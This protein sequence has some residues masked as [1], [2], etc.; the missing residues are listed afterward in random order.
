M[1][2]RRR[3]GVPRR[4]AGAGTDHRRG[5]VPRPTAGSLPRHRR[6]R[7][8]PPGGGPPCPGAGLDPPRGA[9][10]RGRSAVPGTAPGVVTAGGRAHWPPPPPRPVSTSSIFS[11]IACGSTRYVPPAIA[12]CSASTLAWS[13]PGAVAAA[14][15]IVVN[16][17]AVLPTSTVSAA[18]GGGAS[19]GLA[20][21]CAAPVSPVEATPTGPLPFTPWIGSGMLSAPV[22]EGFLPDLVPGQSVGKDLS[23]C[24]AELF[25]RKTPGGDR[26]G[27][28]AGIA[29]ED[30]RQHVL[31]DAGQAIA[32]GA[33]R[34]A[35][36]PE[37]E[38]DDIAGRGQCLGLFHLLPGM[39]RAFRPQQQH[40]RRVERHLHEFLRRRADALDDPI[41]RRPGHTTSRADHGQPPAPPEGRLKN[42][43]RK[44]LT[45]S[46]CDSVVWATV[47]WS[48]SCWVCCCAC[49][50]SAATCL[51]IAVIV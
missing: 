30:R 15:A 3:A 10:R 24:G 45:V 48:V 47:N 40:A 46:S 5:R 38:L 51:F 35:A 28:V 25:Q 32:E 37:H 4:C 16:R 12:C 49:S 23:P 33:G 41:G 22:R 29:L 36:E 44:L 34:D 19:C 43:L 17:P 20:L 21:P 50:S 13:M 26:L 18:G 14:S 8:Y 7:R 9:P 11:A 27:V 31:I 42:V 6:S 39:D 2:A 1:G